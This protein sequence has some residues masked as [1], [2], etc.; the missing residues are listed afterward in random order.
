MSY[1]SFTKKNPPEQSKE[2]NGFQKRQQVKA[3]GFIK[4]S[5]GFKGGHTVESNSADNQIGYVLLNGERKTCLFCQQ[6]TFRFYRKFD[7]EQFAYYFNTAC[8]NYSLFYVIDIC[9]LIEIQK[10]F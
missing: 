8:Q 6:L 1:Q 2:D 7:G 10:Q 9:K 4:N 3:T 5:F